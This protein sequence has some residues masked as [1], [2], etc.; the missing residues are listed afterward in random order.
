MAI[1]TGPIPNT[2]RRRRREHR[3][4]RPEQLALEY[5]TRGLEYRDKAWAL[6]EKAADSVKPDK[7]LTKAAKQLNVSRNTLYRKMKR[8]GITPPR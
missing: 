4:Q 6:E 5:Y 8:H 2:D 1:A 7:L 3:Q